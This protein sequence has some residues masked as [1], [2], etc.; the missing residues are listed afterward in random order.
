[1]TAG[2]SACGDPAAKRP[3][4]CRI[5][6]VPVDLD[7]NLPRPAE[8]AVR[9]ATSSVWGVHVSPD[10]A[11][12]AFLEGGA[13]GAVVRVRPSTERD[14]AVIGEVASTGLP[15]P[16]GVAW[17]SPTT[18]LVHQQDAT[19]GCAPSGGACG[20]IDGWHDVFAIPLDGAKAA[21][22]S[23]QVIGNERTSLIGLTYL[24]VVQG[25][26]RV[27]GVART[28]TGAPPRCEDAATC[29][30]VTAPRPLLVDLETGATSELAST[31]PCAAPTPGPGGAQV[32]CVAGTP[33]APTLI[34]VA[35][36]RD[37]SPAAEL[38]RLPRAP[39]DLFPLGGAVT[40]TRV[41]LRSPRM[42]DDQHVAVIASC[43]CEGADCGAGRSDALAYARAFLVDVSDPNE[44]V[45]T[46]LL[47]G[48][49]ADEGIDRGALFARDLAC[50]DALL[51]EGPA[52]PT[53]GVRRAPPPAPTKSKNAR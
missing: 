36:Q 40:C 53:E 35:P 31:G 3:S 21:G 8:P 12:L 16:A 11:H 7:D 28:A 19:A 41:D 50:T 48:I 25:S 6:R 44:H 27:L 1:V 29:G 37:A 14:P 13:A 46:D 43:A 10:G 9:S 39:E 47:A 49:E 20:P 26:S 17:L 4:D 24:S 30:D 18:V 32:V 34:T 52:P 5:S 23:R 38:L 42:C 2:G 22:A 33:T 45:W 15:D 51:T